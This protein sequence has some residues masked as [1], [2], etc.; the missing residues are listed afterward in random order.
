MGGGASTQL[1][2]IQRTCHVSCTGTCHS[3]GVNAT[4]VPMGARATQK[5]DHTDDAPV[6]LHSAAKECSRRTECFSHL[7]HACAMLRR[8]A[9]ANTCASSITPD[10]QQCVANNGATKA[11]KQ[12]VKHRGGEGGGAGREQDA[13]F[14]AL[15]AAAGDAATGEALSPGAAGCGMRRRAQ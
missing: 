8:H 12:L 11:S 3:A 5:R 2:T 13:P 14:A 4:A 7:R 10:K 15:D 1:T 6:A 9:A